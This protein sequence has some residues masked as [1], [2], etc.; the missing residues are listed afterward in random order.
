MLM[1]QTAAKPQ[2][3]YAAALSPNDYFTIIMYDPD[4]PSPDDPTCRNWLHWIYINAK[5][6]S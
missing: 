2:V 4:A 5:G 1:W 6:L 3:D